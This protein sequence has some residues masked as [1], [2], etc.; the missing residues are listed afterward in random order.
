MKDKAL[1]QKIY[2][3]SNSELPLNSFYNDIQ[4]N[5]Q[6]NFNKEMALKDLEKIAG[7]IIDLQQKL[8][9]YKKALKDVC[10]DIS[11]YEDITS[12]EQKFKLYLIQAKE[13]L[14]CEK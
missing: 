10:E 6:K 2:E 12:P 3:I 13:N 11:L 1:Q 5:K 7:F 9:V 8:E 14:K 4:R